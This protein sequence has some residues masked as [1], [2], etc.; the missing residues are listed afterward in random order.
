[1]RSRLL[2]ADSSLRFW[3]GV[4]VSKNAAGIIGRDWMN[5]PLCHAK[6]AING[7]ESDC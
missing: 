4:G 2:L 6:N 3:L 5:Q 1:M 7:D